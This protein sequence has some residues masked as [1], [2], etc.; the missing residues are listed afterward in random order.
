MNRKMKTLVG[1]LTLAGLLIPVSAHARVRA[2]GKADIGAQSF[3]R[4]LSGDTASASRVCVGASV[5]LYLTGTSTKPSTY[6]SAGNAK[7]NP[8]TSNSNGEWHFYV[9]PGTYDYLIEGCGVTRTIIGYVAA[10]SDASVSITDFGAST[11][12]SAAANNTAI[13]SACAALSAGSKLVIPNGT[14]SVTAVTCSASNIVIEGPGTLTSVNPSGGGSTSP[15]LTLSG[16]N[17]TVQNLTITATG[18]LTGSQRN[19][20]YA[21]GNGFVAINVKVTGVSGNGMVWGD[22]STTTTGGVFDD[23]RLYSNGYAGLNLNSAASNASVTGGYFYSNGGN[24]GSDGYGITAHGSDIRVSGVTAYGN[25]SINIDH[26]PSGTVSGFTVS[27]STVY[28]TGV[29]ESS[30]ARGI[31]IGGNTGHTIR[32][33][34]I[35][36]NAIDGRGNL[37]TTYAVMV[38]GGASVEDV[39]IIG[40]TIRDVRLAAYLRPFNTKAITFTGNHIFGPVGLVG[41]FLEP[42]VVEPLPTTYNAGLVRITGNH[43]YEAGYIDL[44]GGENVFIDANTFTFIGAGQAGSQITVRGGKSA[45]SR[46][47]IGPNNKA[48]GA[49]G[50][51]TTAIVAQASLRGLAAPTVFSW[52]RG[53][54]IW[55]TSVSAGGYIGFVCTASGTFGDTGSGA[56]TATGDLGAGSS[57][58]TITSASNT[59]DQIVRGDFVTVSGGAAFSGLGYAEVLAINQSTK[60]LTLSMTNTGVAVTGATIG[61]ATP[62]FKEFGAILP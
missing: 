33:V 20:I 9:D 15:I 34:V 48:I 3:I 30:A 49:F 31:S 25:Y 60:V 5:T 38:S 58:L 43:F 14:Y 28:F 16:T 61:F 17:V 6:D 42:Q 1:I 11:A 44:L 54:I 46:V 45:H 26:H 19:G 62:A 4:S 13:T 23:L 18:A 52:R 41:L 10:G 39:L 24:N 35:S 51:G 50:A 59:M 36:G 21:T 55:G 12:G 2:Q 40:N 29:N 47:H 8:T 53:D 37:T 57:S 22:G 7:A 56:A 27:G 32:N